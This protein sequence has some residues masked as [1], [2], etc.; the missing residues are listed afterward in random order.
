[1]KAITT[2]VRAHSK[3]HAQAL[4]PILYTIF[5]LM[6]VMNSYFQYKLFIPKLGKLKWEGCHWLR[7]RLILNSERQANL[8]HS[9]RLCSKE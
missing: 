3:S 9:V 8:S 4:C 6:L 7:G 1:M 2:T 5:H